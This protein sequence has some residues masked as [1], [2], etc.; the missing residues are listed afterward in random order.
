MPVVEIQAS[1]IAGITLSCCVGIICWLARSVAKATRRIRREGSP[2]PHGSALSSFTAVPTVEDDV[3]AQRSWDIPG[4]GD[5]CHS[6]KP[7]RGRPGKEVVFGRDDAERTCV[8]AAPLAQQRRRGGGASGVASMTHPKLKGKYADSAMSNGPVQ[9]V[10]QRSEEVALERARNGWRPRAL[11]SGSLFVNARLLCTEPAS[12]SGAA[13]DEGTFA[14]IT[15]GLQAGRLAASSASEPART[16]RALRDVEVHAGGLGMLDLARMRDT[17]CD[18][19]EE[20]ACLPAQHV[21][22]ILLTYTPPPVAVPTGA[23]PVA[24]PF[25]SAGGVSDVLSAT[26]VDAIIKLV[27]GIPMPDNAPAADADSEGADG[28]GEEEDATAAAADVTP[29]DPHDFDRLCAHGPAD[30]AGLLRAANAD[31]SAEDAAAYVRAVTAEQRVAAEAAMRAANA[32]KERRLPAPLR[33]STDA[34]APAHASNSRA[35][36]SRASAIGSRQSERPMDEKRA[37]LDALLSM[38]PANALDAFDFDG[39]AAH[40]AARTVPSHMADLSNDHY[41]VL[42]TSRKPKAPTTQATWEGSDVGSCG[43]SLGGGSGLSHGTASASAGS[44]GAAGSSH[45]MHD[46]M[47]P[48]LARSLAGQS[49]C[50]GSSGSAERESSEVGSNISCSSSTASS[51]ASSGASTSIPNRAASRSVGRGASSA[52]ADASSDAKV[53]AMKSLWLKNERRRARGVPSTVCE[54]ESAVC[55]GASDVSALDQVAETEDR[56]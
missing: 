39:A 34:A 55:E 14:K 7:M 45:G 40:M 4:H 43:E 23:R 15:A 1:V 31:A 6:V 29:D 13:G 47:G 53:A 20:V 26:R 27:E 54:E 25:W 17:I 52:A 48:S 10:K 18:A 30:A 42:T 3:E 46:G 32:L 50:S 9:F 19:V 2:S 51:H 35:S 36:N 8:S 22:A 49:S 16:T 44:H 56:V 5:E 24:M 41:S 33:R 38:E 21:A 37:A 28:E 11:V 12:S